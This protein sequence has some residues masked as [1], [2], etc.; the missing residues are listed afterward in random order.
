MCTRQGARPPA[1]CLLSEPPE[2]GGH[3][4]GAVGALGHALPGPRQR[5]PGVTTSAAAVA[6]E[7]MA[8]R[9]R[10]RQPLLPLLAEYVDQHHRDLE[11]LLAATRQAPPGQE[12]TTAVATGAPTASMTRTGHKPRGQFR[13]G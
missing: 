8:D 7:R 6:V 2:L 5:T 13:P 9:T 10:Q 1:P 3:R 4:A 12:F 11:S